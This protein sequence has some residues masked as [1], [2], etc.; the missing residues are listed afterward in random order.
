MPGKNVLYKEMLTGLISDWRTLWGDIK[1]PFLFV[2]LPGFRKWLMD[3]TENQ[4]PIIRKC[5]QQ[6]ADTV[7]NAYLC[8]ISDA[9]EEVDIHPKNKKIV[10]ERLALLAKNYVYHTPCMC[11]APRAIKR[12]KREV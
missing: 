6:V 12:K 4:Y 2:Q 7:E 9:G 1:L 8:S 11:E 10:G 3:E 5:Q